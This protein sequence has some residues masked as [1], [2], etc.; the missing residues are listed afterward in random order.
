MIIAIT[1]P[2]EPKNPLWTRRIIEGVLKELKDV[3]EF[4]TGAA[5]G[6]DTDAY[7]LGLAEFPHASHVV[8]FPK[9]ERSNQAVPAHACMQDGVRVLG[10]PGGYMKRN[11]ALVEGIMVVESVVEG[12]EF[13]PV[14]LAVR[15]DLLVAFPSGS[16]E[17]LRSGTWATIRRARKLGV[18]VSLNPLS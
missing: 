12:E 6:V 17:E 15:A 11:D 14:A 1:G 13:S 8:C 9:G 3:T 10:I 5:Y 16:V 18:R 4:R 2:S 7:H